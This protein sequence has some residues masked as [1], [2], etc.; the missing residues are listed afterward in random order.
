VGV[1]YQVRYACR[2]RGSLFLIRLGE[3]S[4]SA[5][6]EIVPQM[7]PC[8]VLF[9]IWSGVVCYWSYRCLSIDMEMVKKMRLSYDKGTVTVY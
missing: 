7:R 5:A 1:V 2:G 8:K 3:H 4:L 6:L 9:I